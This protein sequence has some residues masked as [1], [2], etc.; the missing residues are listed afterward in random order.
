MRML[1]VCGLFHV[2]RCGLVHVLDC[3]WNLFLRIRELHIVQ[4]C[5]IKNFEY[6]CI[7]ITK[8]LEIVE[9]IR[10]RTSR[11]LAIAAQ[12]ACIFVSIDTTWFD[13]RSTKYSS[14]ILNRHLPPHFPVVKSFITKG[15]CILCALWHLIRA[16][17]CKD[18][19]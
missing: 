7:I 6:L 10:G 9:S 13:V 18:I 19:S 1:Y 17:I 16:Y 8:L 3:L 14:A 5:K 12:F 4:I 11:V 15:S 2:I